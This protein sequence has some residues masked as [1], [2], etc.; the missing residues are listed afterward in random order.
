M[1]RSNRRRSKRS[2]RR[3]GSKQQ[4]DGSRLNLTQMIVSNPQR[5]RV[6]N[7]P[8]GALVYR[9]PV[10]N[11]INS[12]ND[13][14]VTELSYTQVLSTTGT[15]SISSQLVINPSSAP[16]WTSFAGLYEEYRILAARVDYNP[17]ALNF[18]TTQVA[19]SVPIITYVSRNSTLAIAAT[20]ALAAEFTDRIVTNTSE[21]W[22]KFWR[23]SG[24]IEAQ[25]VNTS[26][27]Y[28][29]GAFNVV[30]PASGTV[31]TNV[32]YYTLT[33]WTQFRNKD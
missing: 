24:S 21:K 8:A 28:S 9:G 2:S 7:P 32:G 1:P 15:G 18:A 33:L 27:T 10:P 14:I 12:A 6:M 22:T 23:M 17:I 3:T 20:Y 16:N 19:T 30:G 26:S 4:A 31:G 29:V 13:S 5:S 11:S 25:F